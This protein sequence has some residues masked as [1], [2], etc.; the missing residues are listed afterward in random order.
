MGHL[1]VTKSLRV[2]PC[3]VGFLN[4]DPAT[5]QRIYANQQKEMVHM[6]F[7]FTNLVPGLDQNDPI[8]RFF[9]KLK[10]WVLAESLG[11][12][13]PWLSNIMI[14]IIIM[15]PNVTCFMV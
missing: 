11:G 15:L 1:P 5:P 2:A 7:L 9:S 4:R 14:S 6:D 10:I 3:K 13:V 8:S 12:V